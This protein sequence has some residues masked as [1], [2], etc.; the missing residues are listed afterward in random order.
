RRRAA[1][2]PEADLRPG[3]AAGHGV[4][5]DDGERVEPL[6]LLAIAQR[7]HAAA[8]AADVGLDDA[9][10]WEL[11]AVAVVEM[12]FELGDRL[13]RARRRER[14]EARVELHVCAVA[15]PLDRRTAEDESVRVHPEHDLGAGR[16]AAAHLG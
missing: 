3:I 1:V 15:G 13:A 2:E 6:V 12:T 5:P 8:H 7:R 14:G 16:A 11:R 10:G 4:G 9:A